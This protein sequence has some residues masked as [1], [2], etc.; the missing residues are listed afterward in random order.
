VRKI[1]IHCHTSNRFIRDV[2]TNY[3]TVSAISCLMKEYE[4]EKT[5]LL[6]TYFPHK[7]SGISNFRLYDW[8]RDRKEFAMFGSLDFKYYPHQG[9][10]EL[11]ELA[12]R[13]LISGIKIYTCYQEV[14]L[15]SAVFTMVL[16]LAKKY[17]LPM[18]FHTGLS[19]ASMRKYKTPTV[20][21]MFTA[22]MLSNVIAHNP[23]V[24]FI[25]S[26]MSKPFFSEVREACTV[27]PNAYTDMSGLIDSK[28]DTHEKGASAAVIREFLEKCGP[29]KLL[30]GTDF[31][32]QTHRDSVS[33][34]EVA[35]SGYSDY[36]KEAVYYRNAQSLIFDR[37]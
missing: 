9:L 15:E 30:F 31:P 3:P 20:S 21:E 27:F 2:E 22:S 24:T 13:G 34:I 37:G 7:K 19:Y 35:M 36:D 1:D 28:F 5:I 33:F 14:D 26:H 16:L 8:I 25:M 18:M 6:A 10:S 17:K 4:I 12:E 29:G 23:D 32:V 11:E